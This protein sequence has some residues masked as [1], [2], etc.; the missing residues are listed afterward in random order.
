MRHTPEVARQDLTILGTVIQGSHGGGRLLEMVFQHRD[1]I[2][3]IGRDKV[4]A[5]RSK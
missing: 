4:L 3:K 1:T 2:N 5:M